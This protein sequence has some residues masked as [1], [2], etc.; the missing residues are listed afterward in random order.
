MINYVS[1][2]SRAASFLGDARCL[3]N[4]WHIQK[5][6]KSLTE[7]DTLIDEVLADIKLTELDSI[8]ALDQKE[9]PTGNKNL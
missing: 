1:N 9:T 2:L 5:V 3:L 6:K 4:G 7:A 8:I